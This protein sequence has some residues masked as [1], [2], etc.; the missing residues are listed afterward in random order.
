MRLA[1]QAA[2]RTSHLRQ[3]FCDDSSSH[4]PAFALSPR[5]LASW[6]GRLNTGG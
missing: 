1:R 6:S 3:P 2:A 4:S 5:P